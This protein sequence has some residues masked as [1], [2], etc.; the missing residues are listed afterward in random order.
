M[1]SSNWINRYTQEADYQIIPIS[2]NGDC[3][4]SAVE[5]AFAYEGSKVTVQ[6]LRRFVSTHVT[7]EIFMTYYTI[8]HDAQKENDADLMMRFMFMQGV[9]DLATLKRVIQTSRFWANETAISILERGLRIKFVIFSLRKFV[10]KQFPCIETAEV[11]DDKL[12]PQWYI[13]L[14]YDGGHYNLVSYKNMTRLT[15]DQLSDSLMADLMTL[16]SLYR[17]KVHGFAACDDKEVEEKLDTDPTT[18]PDDEEF[19]ESS[20]QCDTDLDSSDPI[21]P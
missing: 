8:W 5:K 21:V 2:G 17:K 4:F 20:P 10:D 9:E 11:I 18:L 1:M 15:Y 14:A 6:K 3:F 16:G 13:L 19:Q 12:D 7:E